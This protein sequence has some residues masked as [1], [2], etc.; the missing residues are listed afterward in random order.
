MDDL[1]TVLHEV[2]GGQKSSV[3]KPPIVVSRS[4]FYQDRSA[5]RSD[6]RFMTL[7]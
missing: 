7:L 2:I 4:R 1:A 6:A 5:K 3:D